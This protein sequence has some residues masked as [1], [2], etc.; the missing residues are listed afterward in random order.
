M[1]VADR[2]CKIGQ[3]V[4]FGKEQALLLFL[5]LFE[6]NAIHRRIPRGH[7]SSPK[8]VVPADIS[9]ADPISVVTA[10]SHGSGNCDAGMLANN[11]LGRSGSERPMIYDIASRPH[12]GRSSCAR[13]P[14]PTHWRKR[15]P[16]TDPGPHGGRSGLDHSAGRFVGREKE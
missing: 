11:S 14:R 1:I 16:S 2:M 8:I 15:S 5:R 7:A 13:Y 12:A 3:T 9:V 6:D 10:R 4:L